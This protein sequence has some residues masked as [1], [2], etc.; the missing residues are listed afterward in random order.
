MTSDNRRS[1]SKRESQILQLL[2]EGLTNKEIGSK[3]NTSEQTVKNI[4]YQL[5][6]KTGTKSRAHVVAKAFQ[7]GW[8]GET[9]TTKAPREQTEHD[10]SEEEK[11]TA[12]SLGDTL[13]IGE[14]ALL[15]RIHI[16]TVR[17]WCNQGILKFYRIGTRGD[18]RLRREDIEEFVRKGGKEEAAMQT[19]AS[20]SLNLGQRLV[21]V[22]DK[23][24]GLC[25]GVTITVTEATPEELTELMNAPVIQV[26]KPKKEELP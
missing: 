25:D 9:A 17:R 24:L 3:L 16:N 4:V 7:E 22:G 12:P 8:F 5:L 15:L 14:V 10:I 11:P 18:R 6:L 21:Q 20:I 26:V 23:V 2:S 1:L 19:N 13:T